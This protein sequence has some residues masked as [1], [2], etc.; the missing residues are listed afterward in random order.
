MKLNV[1]NKIKKKNHINITVNDVKTT[2]AFFEKYFD[3]VCIG[4]AGNMFAA[5]NDE[6]G[7]LFNLIEG[8]NINYP[9]TF[10]I[11]F[12]QESKEEVDRIH[13]ILKNDGYEVWDPE[14]A[15]ATYTF[16]FKAPGNFT[17][18]VY[19]EVQEKTETYVHSYFADYN[20]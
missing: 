3:L 11:G 12:P 20:K 6:D 5:M 16:Y 10:H 7:F 8:E 19:C 14:M 13:Q 17:V 2:R 15:H 1:R 9:D 18:E 4:S